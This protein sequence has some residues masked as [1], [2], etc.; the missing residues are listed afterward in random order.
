MAIH[1]LRVIRSFATLVDVFAG[2]KKRQKKQGINQLHH[3]L[4]C[5]N[6]GSLL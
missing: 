4:F 1:R 6:L 5:E 3:Y 2:Y